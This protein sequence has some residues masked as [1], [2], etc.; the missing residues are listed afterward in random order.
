MLNSQMPQGEPPE[1]VRQLVAILELA[2]K[3]GASDVHLTAGATP[4]MRIGGVLTV[5]ESAGVMTRE[6]MVS[7]VET[8][9]PAAALPRWRASGEEAFS[10]GV[11]GVGRFRISAYRQRGSPSLAIR[12]VPLNPV[13]SEVIGLPD[14][15]ARL[16]GHDKGIVFVTGLSGS[17]KST[18][19]GALCDL[20]N[21]SRPCHII[22][23]EDPIEHFH[24][25]RLALFDQ[26]EIGVDT[27][28]FETGLKTALT[29][30]PDVIVLADV[31]NAKVAEGILC[32]SETGRLVLATLDA[33]N[34]VQALKEFIQLFPPERRDAIRLALARELQGVVAQHL[35]PRT[36]TVANAEPAWSPMVGAFEV[37]VASPQVRTL[38]ETAKLD[39]VITVM[40]EDEAYGM[41]RMDQAVDRLLGDG[42]ISIG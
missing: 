2:R 18:T 13:P 8:I 16:V 9:I 42:A 7:V 20:I 11:F 3:A 4:R 17:G 40:G 39:H 1:A 19:L 38:I 41:V 34:S 6:Q 10:W 5:L 22:S 31:P 30:D 23:L 12:I 35:L 25:H 29:A 37:L 24:Q 21:R 33:R 36:K 27:E 15:A 32:A 28:S 26:R 14:A